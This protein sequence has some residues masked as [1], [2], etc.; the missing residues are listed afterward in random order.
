[1]AR[2]TA[3]RA[4][5]AAINELK[6]FVVTA[7]DTLRIWD[8]HTGSELSVLRGPNSDMLIAL[9]APDGEHL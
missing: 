3:V 9:F 5:T 4:R 2:D 7:D 8:A 1:M 6:A